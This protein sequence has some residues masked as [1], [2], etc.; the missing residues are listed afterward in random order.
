M[1]HKMCAIVLSVIVFSVFVQTAS[2]VEAAATAGFYNNNDSQVVYSGAWSYL[3]G[4]PYSNAMSGDISFTSSVG[5]S[6][7]LTF[8]GQTIT[9]WYTKASSRGSF[10][11]YLDNN[12]VETTSA[13]APIVARQNSRT[14]RVTNPSIDHTIKIVFSGSGSSLDIDA[15]SVDVENYNMNE[16]GDDNNVSV[17]KIGV[18]TTAGGVSGAYNGTITYSNRPGDLVRFAFKGDTISLYHSKGPNYGIATVYIDGIEKAN[19]DMWNASY[20]RTQF[21]TFY[22][23]DSTNNWLSQPIPVAYASGGQRRD[24]HVIEV[25]VSGSKNASATDYYVDV[26]RMYISDDRLEVRQDVNQMNPN[27]CWVTVAQIAGEYS[28]A[29]L[30]GPATDNFNRQCQLIKALKGTSTCDPSIVGYPWDIYN[31]LSQY[32]GTTSNYTL[33]GSMT[34][35]SLQFELFFG[36]PVISTWAWNFPLLGGHLIVIRGYSAVMNTYQVVIPDPT[37]GNPIITNRSYSSLVNGT[38]FG[39]AY[40]WIGSMYGIARN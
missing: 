32:Y 7:Q 4:S 18:W 5:A 26:D 16:P 1:F 21:V 23:L 38:Q 9:Y 13:Y 36:R 30:A 2:K 10:Q 29:A 8:Y 37:S 22:N 14:L 25:V 15:F 39:H 35:A 27:W 34:E 20:M 31:I 40:D 28:T 19:I 3:S 12:L 24:T 6:V 33:V 11:V 17:R